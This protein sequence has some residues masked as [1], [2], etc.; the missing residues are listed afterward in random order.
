M[1][2]VKYHKDRYFLFL[3]I[4][5]VTFLKFCDLSYY[6]IQIQTI[7]SGLH[8]PFRLVSDMYRYTLL[9]TANWLNGHSDS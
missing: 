8:Q 4:F 7:S 2:L 5:I 3:N 6:L 9:E 1:C